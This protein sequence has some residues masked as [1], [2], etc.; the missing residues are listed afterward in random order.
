[1]GESEYQTRKRRIDP[2]LR[3][4]GW[5]VVPFEEGKELSACDRCAIEEYPT[6]HGPADYVLCVNGFIIGVVEAKRLSLGPQNVLTQAERYARG[7]TADSFN[8]DGLHAPFLYSTNGEVIW[9]HDVRHP[10]NRSQQ[11]SGFHTPDALLERLHADIDESCT[12]FFRVPDNP[13]MRPY[14]REACDVIGEAISDKKRAMLVAMATGTGK[15]YTMVNLIY[16]LMKASV[17]QRILFLVD[18]RALAAQAVRAFSSFETEQGLKFDKTYEV[19]SQQF[20]RGDLDENEPYNVNVLPESYLTD[21]QPGHSFVYVSTIQRMTINLFGKSAQF[22][23]DEEPEEDARKIDIPIHAFDLIIAD[24]CHRGY[25]AQELSVWRNTLDHFNAIKIGLTATPASHTMAY[26]KHKVYEYGYERAVR[27]GYLV[28]YDIVTIESGVRMQGIFLHEGE[29]VD[30]VDP[31]TGQRTLDVL[32][33]EREFPSEQIERSITSIDSNRKI[34]EEIQRY[35]LEHEERYGRFPKTLIFAA[36]DI[37]HISHADQLVETARDVF[38]R[39]DSFVQKI[40]GKVDRPL[41]HLREFRNRKMPGIVVT[42]DLLSTGVDIPDLE[43]IV[44]L[45]PVK[46]RIL[47]E[48]MMGRGTRKGEHHPDKSHFVVFDCFGGTLLEYFRQVTGITA[49]PPQR[50]T[51]PITQVIDEIWNNRD[52]E[53]NTRV[54]V[55]RINRIDKEMSGEAR[56][57]FSAFVEKGDLKKY[58]VSL[59]RRLREDFTGTMELLRNPDFQ[60]L[61]LHYPR[62]PKNFIVDYGTQDEVTSTWVVRDVDGHEYKPADYLTQFSR[63]VTEN[64]E[65]I[66]AIRILLNRPQEWGTD[67]LG[68]LKQKLAATPQRFTVENLERAH[69]VQYHKALVDII[70]MVK[71]AASGENELLTAEERILHACDTVTAGKTFTADQKE[72]LKRIRAHLIENLSIDQEDFETIPIFTDHGGWGRANRIFNNHLSVL[73]QEFNEAVAV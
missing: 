58:A 49:E 23:C 11:I 72:W 56:D 42:V 35:G 45:R 40:T 50:E 43:Y 1:M 20:Q 66:E 69:R 4:A 32:E 25:T 44:F 9:Y 46:S 47:F 15:T 41:Q 70:S 6:A 18:R 10:L 13:M 33:D 19:Y 24:E 12:Q 26:F 36:Q 71:H 54:L 65:K 27:E 64:P 17:A 48:Q 73:I 5:K 53:Y 61:L 60:N 55:K 38:G 39:G 8:F 67:A 30:M 37:P 52:R 3:T 16:R 31:E 14:Q 68:E 21:P 2:K 29:A 34:I 22:S 63:F 51:K 62:P 28:D 59:E 7:I 57:L